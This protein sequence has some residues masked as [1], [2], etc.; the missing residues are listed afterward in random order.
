MA[1]KDAWL[2]LW[3]LLYL[4]DK[5]SKTSHVA[6]KFFV[7]VSLHTL[8][9][10]LSMAFQVDLFVHEFLSNEYRPSFVEMHYKLCDIL[11]HDKVF[12]QFIN[13][14]L[15]KTCPIPKVTHQ[16]YLTSSV[17]QLFFLFVP[18]VTGYR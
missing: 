15:P 9:Y 1:A 4:E 2:N 14:H 12:S 18:I 7:H 6:F 3:I 11:F 13:K 8:T 16:F 10:H 5:W 17:D